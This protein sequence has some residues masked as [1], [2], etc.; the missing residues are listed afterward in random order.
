MILN[1]KHQST[2]FLALERGFEMVSISLTS[3][4]VRLYIPLLYIETHYC[5]NNV[6][7]M[8]EE[9]VSG[10]QLQDSCLGSDQRRSKAASVNIAESVELLN[11]QCSPSSNDLIS[12]PLLCS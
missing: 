11:S 5:L 9:P 7:S 1:V 6:E 3:V 10:S 8:L 12:R 4:T 2:H